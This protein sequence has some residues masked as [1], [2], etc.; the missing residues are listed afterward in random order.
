MKNNLIAQQIQEAQIVELNKLLIEKRGKIIFPEILA[1][2]INI[3]YSKAQEILFKL[4]KSK[5]TKFIFRVEIHE[6]GF[7]NDYE[8]LSDIPEELE[9]EDE[10]ISNLLERTYVLFKVI[11]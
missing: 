2:R 9:I 7:F 8:S 4:E 3:N 11:V 5:I 1:K 10:I 6:T